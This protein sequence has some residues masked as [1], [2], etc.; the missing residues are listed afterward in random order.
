MR[1]ARYRWLADGSPGELDRGGR[2][3]RFEENMGRRRMDNRPAG[4][5]QADAA[6][7][8]IEEMRGHRLSSA[9]I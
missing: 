8:T 4:E 1:A 9:T 2:S 7:R 3:L 5:L 6:T